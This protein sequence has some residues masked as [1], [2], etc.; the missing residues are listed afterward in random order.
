MGVVGVSRKIVDGPDI[1]NL[2]KF[3]PL[4]WVIRENVKDRI[5]D[6]VWHEF[7]RFVL[8]RIIEEL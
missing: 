1:W 5:T 2:E 4:K 6:Q 7:G 8:E 3:D